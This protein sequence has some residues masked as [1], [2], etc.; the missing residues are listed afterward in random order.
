M[1]FED[2]AVLVLH[3]FAALDEVGIAE[4]DLPPR[5]EAKEP[6]GRAFHE[7][8]T[9]DVQDPRERELARPGGGVLGVVHRVELLDLALGVVREH[10]PERF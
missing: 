10:D 2:V 7:V 1:E 9:L 4:A 6:L 3:D 5:G 8:L